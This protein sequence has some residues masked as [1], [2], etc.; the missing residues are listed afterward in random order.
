VTPDDGDLLELPFDQYQRY[1]V[2]ARLLA[3]LGLE[4]GERVLDV[5]GGPGPIER[6]VP[7]QVT[8]VA[9]LEKSREGLYVNASGAALPFRSGAFS[10][11]V[12]FDTL[13]HVFPEDRTGFIQE[14]QRVSCDVVILTAPFRDPDVELAEAAL[15]EFFELRFNIPHPML[16][17]HLQF[18]LPE[19]DAVERA[20]RDDGWTTAT[21]PSGFLPRWLAMML[22]HEELR[23]S[24]LPQLG[25]VHAYYNSAVSPYDCRDPAYRH[26]IVASRVRDEREL[27]EAAHA[28]RTPEDAPAASSALHAIASAVFAQRMGT[29][30]RSGEV[31]ALETERDSLRRQVAA[32]EREVAD[33]DAHLIELRVLNEKLLAGRRS[34]STHAAGRVS[35]WWKGRRP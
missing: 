5:G 14:L 21:L 19:L 12:T 1:S 24:L 13:E 34:V 4:P 11:V 3:E 9:D 7:D 20:F 22:L 29:V 32:L 35:A 30:M 31:L 8:Y 26:V 28:L 16:E 2:T 33:R 18:G 23:A 17:E 25:K 15:A 27:R 10:A 6:F